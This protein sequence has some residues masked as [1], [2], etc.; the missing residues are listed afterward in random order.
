[1]RDRDD[2]WYDTAQICLNGHVINTM[3]ISYPNSNKKFCDRCGVETITTCKSCNTPIK[4]Y[5]HVPGVI[6]GFNYSPPSFCPNCGV[7]YPWTSAKL[8]AAKEFAHELDS[9]N[10]DEKAIL[11]KSLEDLAR[12]TPNTQVA[13]IKFKKLVAKAGK[14]AAE[15]FK[16]ILVDVLSETAK[17]LIGL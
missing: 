9:L 16:S 8:K 1:M 10:Q 3:A 15:G 14:G 12:D 17:K 2:S 5:Y 11:E 7:P 13:A 6:G 4:G